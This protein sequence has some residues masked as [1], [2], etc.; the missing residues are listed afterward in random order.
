[1]NHTVKRNNSR[2]SERDKTEKFHW[3]NFTH[4]EENIEV[5]TH[6]FRNFKLD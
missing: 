4:L 5:L 6:I 2:I 1:M 3:V